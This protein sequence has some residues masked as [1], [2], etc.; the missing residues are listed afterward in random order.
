MQPHPA[1]TR[2]ELKSTEQSASSSQPLPVIR[3]LAVIV[4]YK[5]TPV[6]SVSSLTLQQALA[7]VDRKR[8]DLRILF[9]DNTTGGQD[10]G[11]LPEG[12]LYEACPENLGLSQA[13]NRA[14]EIAACEGAD[15]LLTLDQDSTLPAN[16]LSE[17]V[18]AID[19][20]SGDVTIAA[21]VPQIMGDG[22]MLSPNYYFLKTFPRYFPTG[23]TG[24]YP[25][26]YAFNSAS[27]LRVKALQEVG[28]YSTLFNFDNS[29]AY[30]YRQLHLHKKRVFVA[31]SI[32]VEHDFS[33]LKMN[34]RITFD[35]YRNLVEA[36][37]AFWDMEFG[38][39]AG[40]YH[41]AS[42][43]YRLFNHWRRGDAAFFRQVT[44]SILKK[45]LFH[46]RKSRIATWKASK[47]IASHDLP[48]GAGK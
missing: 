31:G 28:G 1:R 45:R 44:L 17:L 14:L 40:M 11:P 18:S 33:L 23:F 8:L 47:E 41:T 38:I 42:L 43:V 26:T 25:D 9:Y 32:Q 7:A 5:H 4:L 48:T 46:S 10:P 29:D 3:I 16:F 2:D 24:T 6:T 22:R 39:F 12:A 36:G 19:R 35:R 15:W 34:E 21:V 30:I 27:T 37:G 20:V 13:Y